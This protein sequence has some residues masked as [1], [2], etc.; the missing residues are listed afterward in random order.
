MKILAIETSCDETAVAV[1]T[2]SGAGNDISCT[3]LGNALFSQAHLHAEYG[4]VYPTLAKR[5]HQKN[6]VPLTAGALKEAEKLSPAKS[7]LRGTFGDGVRDE[8][9]KNDIRQFLETTQ[10]PD[11]D[12]FAVTS[13]PGLE[14]ALWTG[15]AFAQALAQTWGIPLTGVDHMEGHIVSGLVKKEKETYTLSPFTFPVLALLISGGH[16]ELVLMKEWFRYELVGKTKDDAVGEAFDKV[17]RMLGLPYPGGPEI[18][19]YAARA[20]ERQLHATAHNK[21]KAQHTHTTEKKNLI[22]YDKILG[23]TFVFPRPMLQDESCDFSFSGL[24]TAVLYTI[25]DMDELSPE[26]KEHIAEAFE[27]AVQDVLTEKVR[28]AL[29]KTGARALAVGGGVSANAHIRKGLEELIA[30]AYP[31]VSLHYPDRSLTGDNAIMIALAAGLRAL[32]NK[33]STEKTITAH[34]AQTLA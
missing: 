34:G 11:I 4:G 13:G 26:D 29:E 6:L 22:I 30:N 2:C 10:K 25:K 28:R 18:G 12:L 19:H 20:R 16:T 27:D 3:V 32:T 5:E 17:A 15:V 23:N 31:D 7:S 8:E 21:R 1:V 14:P 33:L 9:F 24:K